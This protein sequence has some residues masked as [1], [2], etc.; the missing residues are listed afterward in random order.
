MSL[1]EEFTNLVPGKGTLLTIGVFDGVHLGHRRLIAELTGQANKMGLISGAI[2]FKQHPL[3]I[4]SSS[5]SPPFITSL[6]QK[7]KLLKDEGIDIIVPLSFNVEV[8]QTGAS[9]FVNLL[10]QRLNM[11]GLVL[12]P[13][14]TLGRRQEGNIDALRSLSRDMKFSLTVVPQLEIDGEIVSSTAIRKAL[15]DGDIR[16]ANKMLG[17]HFSLEEDVITGDNRGVEVLG[18]PTANMDIE[19]NRAL[20]C[21]GVYATIAY[22]DRQSYHS[23]TAIGTN[24]TFNVNE[25]RVE[26]HIIGFEGDLYRRQLKIDIIDRLRSIQ[27]FDTAD[28]LKA[29]INEDI[30]QAEDILAKLEG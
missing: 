10:K 23:V 3:G 26:T 18:F 6:S 20:P 16:K 21:E 28:E 15:A 30:L 25:R 1:E 5:S 14:A 27:K 11:C 29:Q 24:P 22:V 13:D 12:G 9:Q 17:R 4:L 7:I 8:A 19:E 2:T